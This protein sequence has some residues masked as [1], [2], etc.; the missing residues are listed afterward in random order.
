MT[1]ITVTMCS[2]TQRQDSGTTQTGTDSTQPGHAMGFLS[3]TRPIYCQH[4]RHVCLASIFCRKRVTR[5]VIGRIT[6]WKPAVKLQLLG[7]FSA[8]FC[9]L[10]GLRQLIWRIQ[11][12]T[13]PGPSPGRMSPERVAF[14]FDLPVST[15]MLR[16]NRLRMRPWHD[17]SLR[18]S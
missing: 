3:L 12:H 10:F 2:T 17:A 9:F 1:A 6:Q 13:L 11:F 7:P 15:E 4:R 5:H 8:R 18:F 16:L 14:S